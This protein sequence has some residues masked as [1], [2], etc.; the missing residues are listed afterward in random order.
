MYAFHPN[1]RFAA[2]IV[3]LGAASAMAPAQLTTAPDPKTPEMETTRQETKVERKHPGFFH[4][5]AKD[6][7]AAQLA[8]AAD[9]KARGN[10]R[11]AANEYLALVH[12]WH[13]EP[14]APTA[15]LA[16]ATILMERGKYP[17]AFEEFQYLFVFFAGRFPYEETLDA[18]FKIANAILDERHMAILGLKGFTDPQPALPLFQQIARNAPFWK[19]AAEVQYRIGWI[20][21]AT[22]EDADAVDSYAAVTQRYP[23]SPFA[24]DAAF[25]RAL[26]LRRVSRSC[27]RDETQCRAALSAL[28]AFL[29]D[30][31]T[32]TGRAQAEQY[33]DELN[34]HLATMYYDRAL[35]YDRIAHRPKAAVIAYRDFLQKFPLSAKA[36]SVTE[37]IAELAALKEKGAEKENP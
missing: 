14:E 18:Q 6:S 1:L 31:P 35:F 9:L 8:Y 32:H 36:H 33:R 3:L 22:G 10:L 28:A 20:M 4:R 37:R 34:E 12:T 25:Q 21:E 26:C 29:R 2:A 11:R 24:G 27:P 17:R 5:P 13:G 19:R 15:Q 30:H 7:P 16:A 23:A